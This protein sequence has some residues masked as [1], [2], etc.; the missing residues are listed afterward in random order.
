VPMI[1]SHT[2][3]RSKKGDQTGLS[4]ALYCTWEWARENEMGGGAIPVMAASVQE[5]A[6]A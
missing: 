6:D 1:A 4:Q 3:G 5:A 2:A